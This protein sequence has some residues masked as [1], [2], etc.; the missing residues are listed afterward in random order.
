[1]LV[2]TD[3]GVT[4]AAGNLGLPARQERGWHR[5]RATLNCGWAVGDHRWKT[6][7]WTSDGG[8][9]WNLADLLAMKPDGMFGVAYDGVANA[10]GVGTGGTVA[11][12]DCAG[13]VQDKSMPGGADLYGVDFVDAD[14]GWAVGVGGSIYR[15]VTGAAGATT[16]TRQMVAT[17]ADLYSVHFESAAKGW[18]VGAAGTI[19]HTP[20]RGNLDAATGGN[21]QQSP[22]YYVLRSQHRLDCGR[23]RRGATIHGWRAHLGAGGASHRRYPC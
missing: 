14:S 17:A 9:T 18:A 4:W 2:S 20:M 1:M 23:W 5:L 22:E 15:T 7:Q 11:R 8:L 12:M 19:W 10:W 13:T 16:W 6:M 3:G 21:H